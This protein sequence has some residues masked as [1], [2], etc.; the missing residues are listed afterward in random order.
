M[1]RPRLIALTAAI[2]TAVISLFLT[3]LAHAAP[4]PPQAR[5]HS[6]MTVIA[7]RP[8]QL[9]CTYNARA[10]AEA[11]AYPDLRPVVYVRPRWCG[12]AR[13][14]ARQPTVAAAKALLILT[15]EALHIRR[16][17]GA[18]DENRTEC[19][20]LTEVR[21]FATMLGADPAVADAV[22]AAALTAH[23]DAGWP[24]CPS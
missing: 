14:F 20:A 22:A 1:S 23:A 4:G 13:S 17:D 18:R 7:G 10:G 15:H 21:R 2:V 6:A 5:V 16:W 19:L 24:G 9:D 3:A 8:F 11:V 12:Q